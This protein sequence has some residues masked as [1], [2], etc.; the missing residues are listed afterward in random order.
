MTLIEC[1]RMQITNEGTNNCKNL[2]AKLKSHETIMNVLQ[3]WTKIII[4]LKKNNI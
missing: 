2:S 3:T 4:I 1:N